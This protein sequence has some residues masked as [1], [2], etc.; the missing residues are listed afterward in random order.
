VWQALVTDLA[1]ATRA[2]VQ[3]YDAIQVTPSLNGYREASLSVDPLDDAAAEL[4]I[5]ERALKVYD[6]AG[7]LQFF[8]KVW[9]PLERTSAGV[10][11]VAR[12]PL[13]EFSWRRVRVQTSYTS[14][15]NGTG[16]WDAGEIVADRIAIQNAY[17]NTYLRM[18]ARQAST[19]RIRTY[20]PGLLESDVFAELVDAA[21]GFFLLE[22]PVDGTPGVMA[23]A[24]VLYPAA[25]VAR[26]EVRF[27]YGDGTIDN[28][29]DYSYLQS[30]PRTRETVSS[31]DFAGNR[32][33]AIA[34]DAAAIA[35]FGLFE[36]EETYSDVIDA[37]LLQQQAQGDLG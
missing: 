1:G 30:L 23:Q 3:D 35:R 20:E 14:G 4:L 19:N 24:N 15:N 34:E 13:A 16:P 10:K 7:V 5:A 29:V 27:E 33:A 25:G 11:V 18:G 28:C 32:I 36:D 2:F 26:E 22:Q 31:S 17:R 8:G 37:N 6:A 12:G 21:G 9:E